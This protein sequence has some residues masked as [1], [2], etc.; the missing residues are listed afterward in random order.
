MPFVAES[1]CQDA[2]ASQRALSRAE[3]SAS[4]HSR[5]H[6]SFRRETGV[7]SPSTL[8]ATKGVHSCRRGILVRRPYENREQCL[9]IY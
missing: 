7:E 4:W 9:M 8:S 3:V 5:E 6:N 2:P 1:R